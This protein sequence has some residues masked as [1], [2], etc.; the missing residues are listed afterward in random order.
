MTT[1][2]GGSSSGESTPASSLTRRSARIVAARALTRSRERREQGRFL[3]EGPQAVRE[4]LAWH[5]PGTAPVTEIFAT[6]DAISRHRD[7]IDTARTAGVTVSRA[8]DDAI[9]SL[10]GASTPQGMVAVCRDITVSL[11]HVHAQT[12]QLIVAM[13]QIR[14]PGNAG[15]VIRVADAA[16]AEALVLSESSVDLYNDKV[17]RASTGSIFHVPVVRDCDLTSAVAECR[18]RRPEIQVLVAD[19]SGEDLDELTEAG[20]LAAPTLWVFG[21]EAW[22]VPQHLLDLADRVVRVP[23]HGRAESLNLATAAAV[24]LYASAR[25]H[26]RQRP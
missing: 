21:N 8:H 11:Y 23:I 25:V 19:G 16:G 24:C 7:I 20:I 15:A 22:G 17:V 4:A 1:R 9:A 26:R 13:E 6:A 12:P 14:D 3:V 5:G 2:R 18:Q 10:S